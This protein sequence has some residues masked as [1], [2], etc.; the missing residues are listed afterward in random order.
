MNFCNYAKMWLLSTQSQVNSYLYELS[1]KKSGT[2]RSQIPLATDEKNY[3]R[4][5]QTAQLWRTLFKLFIILI[6]QL[7]EYLTLHANFSEIKAFVLKS[8]Y[9]FYILGLLFRINYSSF[10]FVFYSFCLF[11]LVIFL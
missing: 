1:I 8:Y 7:I 4:P 5:L 10:N 9:I 2:A 6:E 3:T 11:L